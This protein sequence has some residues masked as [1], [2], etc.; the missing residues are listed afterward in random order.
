M[1]ENAETTEVVEVRPALIPAL[2]VD[3]YEVSDDLWTSLTNEINTV[4]TRI[5]NGDEL[6]PEDVK[7]VRSLKKQV[8]EYLTSFNKAM[9]SA[10]ETYKQKIAQQLGTLGYSRIETYI[11]E[12]KTRESAVQNERVSAKMN[13]F[14]EIVNEVLADTTYVKDTVLAPEMVTLLYSRF[15]I[16]KSAAKTSTVSDW[17]PYKTL[18]TTNLTMLDTFFGDEAF[19]GATQLPISSATIQQ[20]M[21][22]LRGGDINDL[23]E[24][25]TIF[26]K[27]APY[28]EALK[29]RQAVTSKQ[30]ALDMIAQIVS[31]SSDSADVKLANISRLI[32]VAMTLSN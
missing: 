31:E 18:V 14:V 5:D 13:K 17:G 12:Q 16:L 27:D 25:R 24:M 19:K 1:S 6:T 32:S 11:N 8:D 26:A 7:N 23:K 15:P 29:L 3:E 9:R 20:L 22:Y 28:F 21:K 4:V 10:Q 2:N 30:V